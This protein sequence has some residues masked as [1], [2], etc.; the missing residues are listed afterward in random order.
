MTMRRPGRRLFRKA[1]AKAKTN[2]MAEININQDLACAKYLKCETRALL[3]PKFTRITGRTQQDAPTMAPI[4]DKIPPLANQPGF[5]KWSVMKECRLSGFHV[6][7]P[8][9]FGQE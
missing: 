4:P 9:H 1:R 3:R 6:R 7:S 8:Y 5:E 2:K